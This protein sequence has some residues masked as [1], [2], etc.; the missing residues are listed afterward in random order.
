MMDRQLTAEFPWLVAEVEAGLGGANWIFSYATDTRD[1]PGNVY[2][3]ETKIDLSGYVQSDLT[4]GFRRSFEQKAGQDFFSWYTYNPNIDYILETVLITSVPMTDNQLTAALVGSPGFTNFPNPALD[5]GTF[6]REHIIHGSYKA[7]YANSIVGS[8][9]FTSTGSTTLVD[10]SDNYFSSLEPTAADC[11]Y[12]YRAIS[13]P[14]P[15]DGLSEGPKKIQMPAIRVI[16][17]SFTV[18]E[19]DLEYMMRLKRSYELANQV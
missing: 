8:G 10:L 17:D 7:H 14:A 11:L 4:V 16:L 3:Q 9:A 12:C 1:L 6:N 15:I 13:L 5:W 18:K 19:P 2:V